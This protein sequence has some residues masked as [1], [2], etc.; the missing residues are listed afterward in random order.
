LPQLYHLKLLRDTTLL[1]FDRHPAPGKRERPELVQPLE[2]G[3]AYMH[4]LLDF[5]KELLERP[6]R[7]RFG[8]I[9]GSTGRHHRNTTK[10]L[11]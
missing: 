5:S 2:P 3:I 4:F 10:M 1:V 7:G 11:E 8:V 6:D 9:S